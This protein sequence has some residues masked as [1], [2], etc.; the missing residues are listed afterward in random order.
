MRRIARVSWRIGEYWCSSWIVAIVRLPL[1]SS[2]VET[3][4][5]TDTPAI[6]TSAWVAR[7]WALGN[8]T[9]TR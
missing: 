6:R 2:W 3:T 4:L 5:P 9:L 8:D 7:S 1:G